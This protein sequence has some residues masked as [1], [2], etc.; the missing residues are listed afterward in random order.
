MGWGG[1]LICKHCNYRFPFSVGWGFMLPYLC[2]EILK[3]IKHGKYGDEFKNDAL[4]H[5]SAVVR[6]SY[7]IYVC[8]KCGK[9]HSGEKIELWN[10]IIEQENDKHFYIS[11]DKLEATH[12]LIHHLVYHCDYCGEE[13]VELTDY[14]EIKCP[15]CKSTLIVEEDILWD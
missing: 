5:P 7:E 2:E 15:H 11:K 6:Q 9:L 8:K 10:P 14:E 1:T 13:M 4:S 3:D 12:Q